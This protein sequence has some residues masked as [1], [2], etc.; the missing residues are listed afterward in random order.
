VFGPLPGQPDQLGEF[1]MIATAYGDRD[2]WWIRPEA[3]AARRAWG[4]LHYRRLCGFIKLCEGKARI[5]GLIAGQ[6]EVSNTRQGPRPACEARAAAGS[7][8]RL[9]MLAHVLA[10][11]AALSV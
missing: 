7:G 6:S 9:R 10:E 5:L 4:D 3:Q 8:Q 2:R 1:V 11:A